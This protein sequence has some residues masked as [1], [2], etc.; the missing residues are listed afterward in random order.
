MSRFKP[1]PDPRLMLKN[2]SKA[3]EN[4]SLSSSSSS[5]SSALVSSSSSLS[6]S[7]SAYS[8]THP[9]KLYDYQNDAVQFL[10]K[11]LQ[12]NLKGAIVNIPMG[13]GKTLIVLTFFNNMFQTFSLHKKTML[14]FT[15]QDIVPHIQKEILKH[16]PTSIHEYII[17]KPYTKVADGKDNIADFIVF[18]ESHEIYNKKKLVKFCNENFTNSFKILLS[19]STGSVRE[20]RD[21][22]T[23]LVCEDDQ[24]E[25]IIFSSQKINNVLD[26]VKEQILKFDMSLD[27]SK[28]YKEKVKKIQSMSQGLAMMH[29]MTNLRKWLA[30]L[31][32]I[33]LSRL[34]MRALHETNEK[35]V[36]FSSFNSVLQTLRLDLPTHQVASAYASTPKK[37]ASEIKMFTLQKYDKRVLLVS[38]NLSSHGIDLGFVKYLIHIE[39]PWK[40]V[41]QRQANARI[42]RIGQVKNQE[43]FVL[44]IRAS[45]EDKLVASNMQAVVK[46]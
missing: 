19:G 2:I 45:L 36:V 8:T 40:G 25:T 12:D 22:W 30:H 6:S 43:I 34:I 23:K 46:M 44:I 9:V 37:R 5:A 11:K 14:F 4:L 20:I 41:T 18:D 7:S 15:K 42:V 16:L 29:E 32:V 38:N 33:H 39:P 3:F 28:E 21:Q 35:I 17:V 24:A 31:K 10:Q 13:L 26:D 1:Y 27:E